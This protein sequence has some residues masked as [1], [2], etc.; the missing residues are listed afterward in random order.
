MG[1]GTVKKRV[2]VSRVTV[3]FAKNP[4]RH[5]QNVRYCVARDRAF[6]KKSTKARSKCALSCR[7]RPC[8]L[9]KSGKGTVGKCVIVSGMTVPFAKNRQRHGQK[10]HSSELGD[11]AFC[12]KSAKAR[13]ESAFKCAWRPCLLQKID[14]GTVEMC[15]IVSGVTVPF[16]KN[17]QRHGRNVRYRV[18]RD[19]AFYKKSAKARSKSA[20]SQAARPCLL[21]KM[22]KGT[23]KKRVL[24]SRVTVPFAK[25]PQRH[26]QKVRSSVERDRAFCR[27]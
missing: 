18:W 24:V 26:G 23:V 4:Q 9:Q 14:K 11:R 10:V 8:L 6:Y 15:V 13:S 12:K 5:G 20:F 7:A 16:A 22:G 3:P 25:N 1:K 19:R 2:L 21:Q 27:K 17:R